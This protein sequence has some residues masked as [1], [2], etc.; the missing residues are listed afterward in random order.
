MKSG[1]DIFGI[2]SGPFINL[3]WAGRGESPESA[4]ARLA[5][6]MS[7]LSVWTGLQWYRDTGDRNSS[8]VRFDLIPAE[9]Q[10]LT[11][12]INPRAAWARDAAPRLSSY[13][14]SLRSSPDPARTYTALLSG[15]AG[16]EQDL[17]NQV[18]LQLADDFPV[19]TP[20]QAARWFLDLVRIWQPDRAR[21]SSQSVEQEIGLTRAAYLSWASVKAYTEPLSDKEIRIPFGD[22][23]LGAARLW[24]VEGIAALDR[25]LRQAKA[26]KA[27][28]RPS[29]QDPPQFPSRYPKELDSLDREV[30]WSPG[31]QPSNHPV[32][33]SVPLFRPFRG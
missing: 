9:Q 22:G 30:T 2:S 32:A 23:A 11:E 4:A 21:M 28:I 29:L 1:K 12:L 8:V 33:G 3:N 16:S 6:T 5:G 20:S 10:G 19:G 15:S 26:P 25:D 14:L 17:S 24:T 13:F 31:I 27:S 7:V 18:K